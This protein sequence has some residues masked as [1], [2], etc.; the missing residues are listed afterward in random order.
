MELIL[1][2]SILYILHHIG[3]DSESIADL[4]MPRDKIVFRLNLLV[5]PDGSECS[6][7]D[8]WADVDHRVIF[9]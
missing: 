7:L 3:L 1:I 9:L 5:G 2:I 8:T 4:R 6:D